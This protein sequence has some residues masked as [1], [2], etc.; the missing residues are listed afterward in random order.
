MPVGFLFPSPVDPTKAI[1]SSVPKRWLRRAEGLAGLQHQQHGGSHTFRRGWATA[2][3]HLPLPDVMKAGGWTDTA[4]I[5]KS[6][7]HATA[8]ETRHAAMFVA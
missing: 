4:T 3:K 6:Y 2:R 7:R 8:D 1:D 5:L